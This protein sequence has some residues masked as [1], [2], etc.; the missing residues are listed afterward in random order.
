MAL[1]NV[2]SHT[3]SHRRFVLV[4]DSRPA[5]LLYTSTLLKRFEYN[6]CPA[7]TAGEALETAS[8]I[9]PILIIT[10]QNLDDMPGSELIGKL[11]Q[12]DSTRAVSTIVLT[13]KADPENERA[14]LAAGAITCLSARTPIEDLY[15][16]VQ[17]AVEPI[18]RMNLRI[19]TKLPITINSN[20]VDCDEG[21]CVQ[22]LSENGAYIR[23]RKPYPL[24]TRLPVQIHLAD[25][26]LSVEAEVIYT[27]KSGNEPEPRVGIGLQFVQISLGDQLRIRKFIRDEITK[28]I[29]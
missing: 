18:P 7:R 17:M 19:N 8:I 11:K 13:R 12:T 16:V 25:T 4:V 24:K 15:R 23:T 27:R 6:V 21:G 1:F 14:C 28:G 5:G 3:A 22:D 29:Q 20:A 10:A 2:V 26:Q 9:T